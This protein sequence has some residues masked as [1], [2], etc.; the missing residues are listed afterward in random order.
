GHAVKQLK[1]EATGINAELVCDSLR[2]RDAADI[3]RPECSSNDSFIFEK[4][5]RERLEIRVALRLLKKHRGI[6]FVLARFCCLII[7]VCAFHQ[8]DRETR[9]AR[10]TP[11]NQIT[12]VA[13]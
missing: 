4:Y 5:A 1:L 10:A 11:G 2:V 6:R 7:P 12:Q 9:A 13:I 3:V 8:P